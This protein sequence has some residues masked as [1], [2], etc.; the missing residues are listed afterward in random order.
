MRTDPSIEQILFA[1]AAGPATV[2]A[3]VIATS[4]PVAAVRSS[5]RRLCELGLARARLD[6]SGPVYRLVRPGACLADV[7][8]AEH[9]IV[10]AKRNLGRAA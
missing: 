1:L 10:D 3:V 6:T 9:A 2:A 8:A 5:M 4:L 7:T